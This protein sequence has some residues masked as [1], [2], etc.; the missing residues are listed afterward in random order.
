[1]SW[2]LLF[3]PA[4]AWTGVALAAALAVGFALGVYLARRGGVF[5]FGE[6][7]AP[8]DAERLVHGLY[9]WTMAMA[10]DVEHSRE[11]LE[12]IVRHAENGEP[13]RVIVDMM[14]QMIEA[15][16][17]MQSR[18]SVA[19]DALSR[20]AV[21]ISGYLNEART[22]ALTGLANRRQFDE[23]LAKRQAEWQRY[24]TPFG[25]ALIDIDHFKQ[26]ND[27][28]G[29]QTGDEVLRTVARVLCTT[30]RETD[31]LARY[32]GEEFAVL[33]T[34]TNLADAQHATERARQAVE[35]NVIHYN[36][37]SLRV[38]V[39]CGL[40]EPIY[41]EAKTDLVER[42]DTALY[43]S[44]DD[45]RNCAHFHDGKCCI[46]L[47]GGEL[48]LATPAGDSTAS[49][50]RRND[51]LASVCDALRQRLAELTHSDD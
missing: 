42:A 34:S 45:G 30:F 28:H 37:Q 29:H 19:E 24:G 40:A 15:N 14:A 17:Q 11:Q 38:T 26:F 5:G 16:R 48:H 10:G 51:D 2:N 33:L 31:L 21:R 22:D 3:S 49:G 39:S 8:D 41:G 13:T 23:E 47:G 9:R 43:T 32:G 50:R 46:R 25:L 27:Q 4:G 18:L 1:M 7:A 35:Q 36:D 12:A 44:K 20:Q 6:P